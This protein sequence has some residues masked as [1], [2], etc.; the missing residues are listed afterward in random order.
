MND[1][2]IALHRK[3]L[4]WEWWWDVN[5]SRL[6]IYMLLCA[7]HKQKKWQN[8]LIY[9]GQFITSYDNLALGTGLTV[10]NVRTCCNKLKSTG[11]ITIKSTNKF[12]LISIVNYDVYQP[13]LTSKSTSKLTNNQ[14]TTN[15]QLTTTNNDNNVNNDNKEY[16][17]VPPDGD[18]L[19]QRFIEA[20]NTAFKREF[21]L[22]KGR[23]QKI[24]LRLKTYSINQLIGAVRVMAEDPF[25]SGSNDR[26]W[27]ADPDF[28][29]RSDEQVDKFLNRASAPKILDTRKFDKFGNEIGGGDNA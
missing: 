15:K 24:K 27:V 7:N 13:Q 17:L 10:Q 28:I 18:T 2:Y 11:E 5:T 19:P 29:L 4:D 16:N 23:T 9:R 12:S 8:T 1:G 3:I 14:Q 26:G 6:F 21:K 25:Y 20:F 22:T